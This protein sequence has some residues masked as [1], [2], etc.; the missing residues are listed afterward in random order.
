M[1]LRGD[2]PSP[3]RTNQFES[4]NNDNKVCGPGTRCCVVTLL[5]FFGFII[6][7]AGMG[8]TVVAYL[9][10]SRP[11]DMFYDA[12]TMHRW[13]GPSLLA[14][15]GSMTTGAT[16]CCFRQCAKEKT[17]GPSFQ[18]GS[19]RS[20]HAVLPYEERPSCH[21]EAVDE[22]IGLTTFSPASVSEAEQPM[23]GAQPADLSA[24]PPSYD[25][26]MAIMP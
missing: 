19:T 18:S 4:S 24:P 26:A 2:V 3:E 13:L 6:A 1:S 8:V 25:E 5:L 12:Y 11:E 9:V 14:L 22:P 21:V 20:T 10:A 16:V 7:V 17:S 23:L 15:G